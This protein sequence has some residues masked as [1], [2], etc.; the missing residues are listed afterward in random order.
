MDESDPVGFWSGETLLARGPTLIEPFNETQIDCNSYVLRMGNQ[1]YRTA[2]QDKDS[3]EFQQKTFLG[4]KEALTIPP[5]QFAFLLCKE[6][7]KVPNDTMAFI[8]MRTSIKFQG[9]INVSGFHVDPGYQGQLVYAVYNASPSSIPLCEGD[10]VFK[11]WFCSMDRASESKFIKSPDEGIYSI[12]NEMVRGMSRE[13]LS[14]Q[15]LA[16]KLRNQTADIERRFAEQKPTIDNLTFVY[17]TIVLGV[18][19]FLIVSVLALALPTLSTKGK[20][21]YEL[22]FH[23]EEARSPLEIR[24]EDSQSPASNVAQ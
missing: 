8:S 21:L 13:I 18:V 19:G 16:D 22:I 4:E 20:E 7:V 2:D 14:L 12:S 10:G 9:L 15:N 5:G 3:G 1:Y 6:I 11:I 23:K 24:P 17:R